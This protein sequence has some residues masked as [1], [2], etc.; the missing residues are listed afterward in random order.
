M[1]KDQNAYQDKDHEVMIPYYELCEM[2]PEY[3]TDNIKMKLKGFIKEDPD[4]LDPYLFL[5]EIYEDEGKEKEADRLLDEAFSKAIELITDKQG[6]WPDI[7]EWAWLENR[8]IIRTI[9]NKALSAW[10]NDETDEA[11]GLL[12]KL[13]RTNPGDNIGA[14]DFILAIRMKM[15]FDEFQDR[16]EKDGYYD[17]E[18]IDWFENNY[19][20][21]PDEFDWWEKAVE[22]YH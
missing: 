2:A 1:T 18:L 20:K 14:R 7:M 8:H 15:S 5:R 22:Q 3:D 6:N 9:L 19:S 13:L 10:M 4:F 17:S 12:R 16:F 11:L 21:F